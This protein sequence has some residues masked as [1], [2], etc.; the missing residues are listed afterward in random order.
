M[1]SDEPWGGRRDWNVR[2]RK[3]QESGREIG[4]TIRSCGLH[5]F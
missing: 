4:G 5:I 1:K 3:K 2:M